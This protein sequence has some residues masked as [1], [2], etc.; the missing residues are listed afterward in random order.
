MA[1]FSEGAVTLT[2]TR[3][4]SFV[5]VHRDLNGGGGDVC[6][7]HNCLSIQYKLGVNYLRYVPLADLPQ[8]Q[9]TVNMAKS[10]QRS[11]TREAKANKRKQRKKKK[12]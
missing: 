3:V 11:G 9:N 12:Q 7:S 5:C 2:S 10:I 8:D 6:L 4:P 1:L